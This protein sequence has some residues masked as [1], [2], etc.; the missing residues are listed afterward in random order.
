MCVQASS[1]IGSNIYRDKDKPLYRTGNKV[2]IGICAYNFILFIG[3]K[4]FY[5][6]INKKRERVW[7]EMSGQ[8]RDHYL[9]T[10]KDKGNK[11]LDFRF[12]H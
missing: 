11:R 3:A 12:A 7:N 8:E 9:A 4:L 5:V 6:Y 10:T 1:I 2:L